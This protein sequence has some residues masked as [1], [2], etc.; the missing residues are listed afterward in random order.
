MG[1]CKEADF[2]KKGYTGIVPIFMKFKTGKATH[3]DKIRITFEGGGVVWEAGGGTFRGLEIIVSSA[4]RWSP[5]LQL[6]KDSLSCVFSTHTL[7]L[8]YVTI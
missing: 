6:C 4:G 2:L 3:G 1:N 5:G 8:M 7:P